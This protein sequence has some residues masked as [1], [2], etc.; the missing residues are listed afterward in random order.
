M[1]VDCKNYESRTYANGEVV[2]KC[3]LDL[4]PEAPWRC[5]DDCVGYERRLM[6]AGWQVG[7]LSAGMEP[8]EPEPEPE[9]DDVAA[10]LDAAEDIV[11]SAAPDIMRDLGPKKRGRFGRR[12]RKKP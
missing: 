7:S 1:R 6:D 8:P 9:G 10:L 4:A 2:R 11:N 12:K 3:R 5:P